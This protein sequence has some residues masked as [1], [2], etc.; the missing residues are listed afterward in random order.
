MTIDGT[1]I[2]GELDDGDTLNVEDFIIGAVARIAGRLDEIGGR[3]EMMLDVM[4][5][6]ELMLGGLK[7]MLA[8]NEQGLAHATDELARLAAYVEEEED[9]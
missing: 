1:D 8:L 9:A 4:S 3:L 2:S 5:K 6:A 7:R